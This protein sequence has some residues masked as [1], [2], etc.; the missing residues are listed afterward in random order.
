MINLL[1]EKLQA[2]V[3]CENTARSRIPPPNAFGLSGGQLGE[4]QYPATYEVN[5]GDFALPLASSAM[6]LFG[7]RLA[8]AP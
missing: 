2:P 6:E 7:W 5:Q 4:T 3:V 1:R 8:Q